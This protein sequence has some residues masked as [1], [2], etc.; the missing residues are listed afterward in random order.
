MWGMEDDTKH[1]VWFKQD[2]PLID[3]VIFLILL[4]F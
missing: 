2:D 4:K 1:D 3:R